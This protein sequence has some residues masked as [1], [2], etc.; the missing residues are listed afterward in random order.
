MAEELS[1]REHLQLSIIAAS[2]LA[3]PS[4]RLNIPILAPHSGGR[5]EEIGRI[6]LALN[7]KEPVIVGAIKRLLPIWLIEVGLF[8][9]RGSISLG[10]WKSSVGSLHCIITLTSFR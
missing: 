5:I 3:K 2:S 9:M 7:G 1:F 8:E 4:I 6:I 10:R